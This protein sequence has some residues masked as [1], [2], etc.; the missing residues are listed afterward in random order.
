MYITRVIYNNFM[1]EKRETRSLTAKEV[2]VKFQKISN[3]IPHIL[4]NEIRSV[5][6]KAQKAN[7]FT[8]RAVIEYWEQLEKLIDSPKELAQLINKIKEEEKE[9]AQP[10]GLLYNLRLRKALADIFSRLH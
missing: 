9:K 6:F 5:L 2:E 10:L 1:I 8:K 4:L 7:R 3:G